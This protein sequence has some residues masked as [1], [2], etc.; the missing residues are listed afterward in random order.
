MSKIDER[1]HE[2]REKLGKLMHAPMTALASDLSTCWGDE[3]KMAAAL[4]AGLERLPYG[5]QAVALT[6]HGERIG[7]LMGR[8]GEKEAKADWSRE[9]WLQE[10]MPPWG[11][12]LSKAHSTGKDLGVTAAHR[13]YQGEKVV[14]LVAV[15]LKL[16]DLPNVEGFDGRIRKWEQIKGDPAIR[17]KLFEQRREQSAMD[18]RLSNAVLILSDLI[19][20]RGLF[21]AVIH[22]S[23]SRTT[24]WFLDDPHRYVFLDSKT[25][26]DPQRVLAFP[27]AKYPE[28]AALPK[29]NVLE[30]LNRMA[31]LRMSDET[32]YLRSASLNIFNGLVSLTFSCDGTHYVPWK[33]FLDEESGF[34]KATGPVS[35]CA[36]AP[37]EEPSRESAKR[38]AGPR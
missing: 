28:D 29:E 25:L 21:Q 26:T 17:S 30:V 37:E 32:I 6:D 19:T 9:P 4:Q 3:E 18:A 33:D 31:L 10:A 27:Q 13:V 12:L 2:D 35:A 5:R 22:F 15:T 36:A 14:G 8:K 7:P 34:W 38:R 24:G 23:G 20:K 16:S 11:F 1:L